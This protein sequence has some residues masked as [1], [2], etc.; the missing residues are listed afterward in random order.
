MGR[1][2]FAAVVANIV[3]TTTTPAATP[4]RPSL[5]RRNIGRGREC[6]IK[7]IYSGLL[8]AARQ[9]QRSGTTGKHRYSRWQFATLPARH[10]HRG[11]RRHRTHRRSRTKT[12]HSRTKR[13]VVTILET[14]FLFS[15]RKKIPDSRT[16]KRQSF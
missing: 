4:S 14:H 7:A 9:I 16:P 3:T 8:T 11:R 15:A 10:Y 13:R 12:R 6:N 1:W 2:R 5:R